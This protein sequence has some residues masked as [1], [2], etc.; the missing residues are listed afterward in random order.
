MVSRSKES[1][2]LNRLGDID[3]FAISTDGGCAWVIE[4][5]DLK[6]CRTVG[7]AAR[8]LMSYRGESR[9][10]KADDMMKH[11]RRVAFVRSNA[12][13]LVERF[14]LPETPRVCG[15]LI[16]NSPQPMQQLQRVSSADSTVIM[17]DKI[18]GIPWPNG[19]PQLD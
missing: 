14:K 1:E 19:W 17:L 10:G 8:R 13:L 15:V 16:V 3:V 9:D 12:H 4:A 7:E 18:G 6:M 11:L 5:K 2:E